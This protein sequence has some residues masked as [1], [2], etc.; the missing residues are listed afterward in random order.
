MV[1][2]PRLNGPIANYIRQT[3]KTRRRCLRAVD[4]M[5]Q[6]LVAA[7][8]PNSYVF[9]FS[10]NGYMRGELRIP[11]GKHVPYKPSAE[12]PML[13][14]GPGVAPGSIANTIGS[15]ID[16]LPTWAELAGVQLDWDV[17]GIS[18]VPVLTNNQAPT[19]RDSVLLGWDGN[20]SASAEELE[21]ELLPAPSSQPEPRTRGGTM[22]TLRGRRRVREPNKKRYVPPPY[23]SLRGAFW[24]YIE[25]QNGYKEY[26]DHTIDPFELNNLYYSSLSPERQAELASRI[27]QLKTCQGQA[28]QTTCTMG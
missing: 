13:V 17:D 26:Y 15:T 4:D 12:V 10:D 23:F 25:W 5:V 1:S 14:R 9:F 18:L 3:T 22:G 11:T 8:P 27:S 6:K 21:G 28:G 7:M 24:L 16:L 2:L 20:T 19:A